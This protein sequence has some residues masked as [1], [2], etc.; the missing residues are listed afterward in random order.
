M[1]LEKHHRAEIAETWACV[2][3]HHDILL[4]GTTQ[5]H[6]LVSILGREAVER[7]QWFHMYLGSLPLSVSPLG[8]DRRVVE[9]MRCDKQEF[10]L[11][12]LI[13]MTALRS[14]QG[15]SFSMSFFLSIAISVYVRGCVFQVSRFYCHV[16]KYSEMPF[17]LALSQQCSN[18]YQWY[19]KKI[20]K[21]K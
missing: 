2:K 9:S 18:E 7:G 15:V 12:D 8:N 17:L 16:H 10:S 20:H 19:Y 5:Y 13:K 14:I 4:T 11:S 1:S 6:S 3:R 21:V